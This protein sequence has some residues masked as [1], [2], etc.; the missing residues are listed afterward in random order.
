[1]RIKG[2]LWTTQGLLAL[3]V[4]CIVNRGEAQPPPEPSTL[5][6]P[7][8]LW[9]DRPLGTVLATAVSDFDKDGRDEIVV[10][11]GSGE[12]GI[13]GQGKQFRVVRTLPLRVVK[14]LTADLDGDG[15][16]EIFAMTPDSLHVLSV[17]GEE[18][19][20]VRG[21]DAGCGP[22]FDVRV[23]DLNRDGRKEVVTAGEEVA[24]LDA[25]GKV[26]WTYKA[27]ASAMELG[28]IEGDGLLEV[29]VANPLT[30]LRYDGK[31]VWSQPD[32]GQKWRWV[33]LCLANVVGDRALE[34]VLTSYWKLQVFDFRGSLLWSRPSGNLSLAVTEKGLPGDST[35]KIAALSTDD[36]RVQLWDGTG[37]L[38]YEVGL[39]PRRVLASNVALKFIDLSGTPE[40]VV[41]A[42]L[43]DTYVMAVGA[44]GQA[45]WQYYTGG[46]V[47]DVLAAEMDGDEYEEV[48]V[49]SDGLY[50][51][52]G[53]G[54]QLWW[55]S[56]GQ[57]SVV[58]ASRGTRTNPG[59]V[60]AG[61]E[62]V[63]RYAPGGLLL[64]ESDLPC[65]HT[66]LLAN[67][68]E[69]TEPEVVI[70]CV[71]NVIAALDADGS[72]LWQAKTRTYEVQVG[73]ANLD[74]DPADEVVAVDPEGYYAFDNDGQR[75]WHGQ[76]S[77]STVPHAPR[78]ISV[79]KLAGGKRDQVFVWC[80]EGF[81]VLSPSGEQ[82]WEV[83]GIGK[84]QEIQVASLG[85]DMP[86]Q[87]FVLDTVSLRVY[88]ASGQQVCRFTNVGGEKNGDFLVS[89]KGLLFHDLDG[90]GRC[91]ILCGFGCLA[92]LQ[93]DGGSFW[94]NGCPSSAFSL[95]AGDLDGDGAPEVVTASFEACV[96]SR[97]GQRVGGWKWAGRHYA[98]SFS[99]ADL[100]GDGRDEVVV[101]ESG[102]VVLSF[103]RAK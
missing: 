73:V 87:V 39:G 14:V 62:T 65:V 2:S 52:D 88:S 5:L 48:V 55:H 40:L 23:G 92:A 98:W 47:G 86:L 19:W 60:F 51:L 59:S 9:Q 13:I 8:V 15:V 1:M 18:L 27:A 3:A 64:W 78:G 17:S 29:V 57:P 95:Q 72:L 68:D 41:G 46:F 79:G 37:N 66:M 54:K 89:R 49:L 33:H 81:H 67:L 53:N 30:V 94:P 80:Q 61:A 91:E 71:D 102:P 90:D 45:R 96:V 31:R 70:G 35:V 99:V 93:S 83:H 69:D 103:D 77:A 56:R 20:K 82:L 58:V 97:S 22:A 10:G 11:T 74:N 43:R 24:C 84:P 32:I 76:L 7:R 12:V 75:L 16:E 6:S 21:E 44:T 34:I 25:H 26:M 85:P 100:N 50:V 63:R 38:I 101:G 42:G 36:L 4:S 28:D